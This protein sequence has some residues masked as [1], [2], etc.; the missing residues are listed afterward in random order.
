MATDRYLDAQVWKKMARRGS[1][2][3]VLSLVRLR[4][5]LLQLHLSSDNSGNPAA[6]VT[7]ALAAADKHLRQ[8][9]SVI[10]HTYKAERLEGS[11]SS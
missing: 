6:L 9:A 7:S 1:A 3:L 11:A 4:E 5:H 10:S 8:G 2:V